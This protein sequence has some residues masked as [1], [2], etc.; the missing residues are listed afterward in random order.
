MEIGQLERRTHNYVRNGTLD[1]FAALNIATGEVLARCKPQHRAQD[2]VE[3]LR[4]IEASVEPALEV[5]VVLDN[6]S[7]HRAPVVHRWLLRHPRFHLH[8]TPTYGSWLNLV[9]RFLWPAHRESLAP[10][11][12]H[13]RAA[14]ASGDPRVRRGAQRQGQAVHMDQ[15]R[16]RDPGQDAT[17]WPPD[18]TGARAMT[19]QKSPIHGTSPPARAEHGLGR[20]CT[21]R[22]ELELYQGRRSALEGHL[23]KGAYVR[24]ESRKWHSR[25]GCSLRDQD[26]SSI[27]RSAT[28]SGIVTGA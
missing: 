4:E 23:S 9:E 26:A 8:F 12:A 16:R 22:G 5:H 17:L 6:L 15:D 11:L 1:L 19:R 2:F 28:F 20:M 24:A 10:W 3:F 13:E 25:A 14:I 27:S 7:A 21:P 18:A